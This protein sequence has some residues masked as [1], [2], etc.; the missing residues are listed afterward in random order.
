MRNGHPRSRNFLFPSPPYVAFYL[1]PKLLLVHLRDLVS[2]K[3]QSFL[4]Y[5]GVSVQ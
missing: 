4:W 5:G 1:L 3:A 2:L